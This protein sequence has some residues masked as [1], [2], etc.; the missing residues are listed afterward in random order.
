M[1]IAVVEDESSIRNGLAKMI[2]RLDPEYELVGTAANGIEGL[3]LVKKTDPD[4]VIMDIQ[5]PEMNGL[6]MLERLRKDGYTGRA[7]VLTAYSDFDYAKRAIGMNIDNYLLKPIKIQEFKE[8]L[9]NIRNALEKEKGIENIQ[10][11]YLSLVQIFRGCALAEF[12]VDEELNR[13]TTQE[14]GLDIREPLEVFSIWM[15]KYYNRQVSEVRQILETYTGRVADYSSTIIESARQHQIL[16]I[17]YHCQNREKILKRYMEMLIPAICRALS[18]VPVF[19]WARSDG[20]A[21]LQEAYEEIIADREWNL[22][23]PR[24]TL[25]IRENLRKMHPVPLKYPLE[26]EET[27]RRMITERNQDGFLEALE[28]F[29]RMYRNGSCHPNE[30]REA[31][32]RFSMAIL[33]LAK[34]LGRTAGISSAQEIVGAISQAVTWNEIRSVM[35]QLYEKTAVPEKSETV[36][37]LVHRAGM[38]IEEYYSQGITLEE[39]AQKLKVSEEYLSTQFKKETGM[40]FTETVRR[41]RIDKIKELLLHSSLKLNQIADM[42]GYSDPKYMSKVFKEEVGVLP[43]EFRKN[44]SS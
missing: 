31:C 11:K 34:T 2:S 17:L 24:G 10:E 23:F 22:S 28:Q 12:P 1:K 39:L 7:V 9:W 36:S 5:M 33:N 8:T 15:G 13:L 18:P 35:E 32:I 6:D 43:A 29:I 3:H 42:V 21:G 4:L 38:L 25:L 27:M 30:I 19:L 16:V 14:Y 44:F 37:D 26:V 20:M 41:Y 40:S